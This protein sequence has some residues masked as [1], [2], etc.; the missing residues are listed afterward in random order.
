MSRLPTE[1]EWEYAWPCWNDDA[2]S[3]GHTITRSGDFSGATTGTS[4]VGSYPPNAWFFTICRQ[5]LGMVCGLE[6]P[7]PER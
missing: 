6:W 5:H 7:Y 4:V 1:A 3:F 2:H